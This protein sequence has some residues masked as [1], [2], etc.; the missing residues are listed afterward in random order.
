MKPRVPTTK[1]RFRDNA[2]R[3]IGVRAFPPY[4]LLRAAVSD[5]D[6][7]KSLC[8][9]ASRKSP[10]T[11]RFAAASSRRAGGGD[12]PSPPPKTRAPV[13]KA[14]TSPASVRAPAAS[15]A[16]IAASRSMDP[17][18]SRAHAPGAVASSS[19]SAR[20]TAAAAASAARGSRRRAAAA[21]AGASTR[22]NARD[23]SGGAFSF[24][25][26]VGSRFSV[27]GSG[28]EEAA[29]EKT[30]SPTSP[31]RAERRP[32][33]AGPPRVRGTRGARRRAAGVA[34]PGLDP[35]RGARLSSWLPLGLELGTASALGGGFP[36]RRPMVPSP[37][38]HEGAGAAAAPPEAWVGSR[39]SLASP[40]ASR[41]RVRARC[42][43]VGAAVSARPRV[44]RRR[45]RSGARP[46][47][48]PA[49]GAR[50]RL[51][52]PAPPR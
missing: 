7:S 9:R 29:T 20:D 23:G 6:R 44:A 2:L 32:S 26:T 41:R 43:F 1:G 28:G 22:R 51:C 38:S 37:K 10:S 21:A 48:A 18:R 12:S 27:L 16:P 45:A 47:C 24:G 15:S 19:A 14:A 17:A 35:I 42:F 49:R 31:R 11:L 50:A 4:L 25:E 34:P 3:S 52:S 40:S 39:D 8:H 36:N 33:A 30:C 5:Y 46:R 13:S